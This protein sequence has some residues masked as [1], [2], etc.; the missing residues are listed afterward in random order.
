MSLIQ[1]ISDTAKWVAIFRAEESERADAVFHDPFARRLAGEK[2]E[3]IANAVEFSK[4]N[5]WSFVARTFLFDEFI[6]KH[7]KQ[8]Y[9]M[10]INLAAGLD[11]RPY[12]M[13]LPSSLRWIEVDLPG[14][15][16]EK[17]KILTDEKP[18]CELRRIQLDLSNVKARLELFQKLNNEADKALI[19]SEGLMIYLT[20][21]EVASLASD[22]SA[23]KKF[24]RWLFD[25]VSPGLL[26]MAQE[27]MGPALEGSNAEFQFAPREGEGFF[28][29]YG[30]KN[31]ESKSKL[32]TAATINRLNDEMMKFAAIPEPEGPKGQF[33]WSGVCLF[34]NRNQ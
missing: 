29:N 21:E 6:L 7:I 1:N 19:V 14:I 23:Q 16:I 24:R 13:E 32:K 17:E 26:V 15:I 8:G 12:R 25:M 31:L 34:E 30:W 22:L 33:P 20:A 2:G 11:A 28:L 27:K 10:I 18:N 3:Q 9:D 5:S 4:K